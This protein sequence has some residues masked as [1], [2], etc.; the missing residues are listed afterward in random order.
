MQHNSINT[1]SS[2]IIGKL[3]TKENNK[4]KTINGASMDPNKPI[5][6]L[7]GLIDSHNLAFP[8]CL[9]TKYPEAS[10]IDINVIRNKRYKFI[11]DFSIEKRRYGSSLITDVAVVLP[12]DMIKNHAVIIIYKPNSEGW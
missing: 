12:I 10:V 9:P 8:K 2:M 6:V 1:K 4:K 5:K 3:Y 11:F 7:L